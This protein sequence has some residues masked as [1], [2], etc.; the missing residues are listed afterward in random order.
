M[1]ETTEVSKHVMNGLQSSF[2]ETIAFL[3]S[4]EMS[5][6]IYFYSCYTFM[7]TVCMSVAIFMYCLKKCAVLPN[8]NI[9][10]HCILK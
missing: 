5:N 6:C 2:F 9:L 10:W 7:T 8:L 4:H 3:L 1:I